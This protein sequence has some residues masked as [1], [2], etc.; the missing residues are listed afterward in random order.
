M[1]EMGK[2]MGRVKGSRADTCIYCDS[3]RGSMRYI[4]QASLCC[5][6]MLRFR[7]RAESFLA[8][9]DIWWVS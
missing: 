9:D 1:Y 6:D 3:Y 4:L 2:F 5:I 7:S 8:G